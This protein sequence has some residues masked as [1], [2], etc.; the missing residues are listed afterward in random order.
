MRQLKALVRKLDE[1]LIPIAAKVETKA[2]VM[3]QKYYGFPG[4]F[5][6]KPYGFEY[7]VLS[8]APFWKKNL[9]VLEEILKEAED[10]ITKFNF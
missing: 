1:K 5:R 7:R 4:E 9:G 2:A 8:C 6:L 3:R 10:I